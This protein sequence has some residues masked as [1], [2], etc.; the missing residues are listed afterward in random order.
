MNQIF[1]FFGVQ[2]LFYVQG[3]W[4]IMDNFII[5]MLII[6]LN[7]L[8][9]YFLKVKYIKRYSLALIIMLP[10]V[11]VISIFINNEISRISKGI[12]LNSETLFWNY[13]FIIVQLIILLISIVVSARNYREKRNDFKEIKFLMLSYSINIV[14][15][16]SLIYLSFIQVPKLN[17]L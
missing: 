7:I 15:I 8:I 14:I 16:T 6:I 9:L 17:L 4:T 1:M 2:W 10:W 5:S 3:L 13:L 12:T 11:Q